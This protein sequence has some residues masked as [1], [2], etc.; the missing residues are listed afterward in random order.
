ME[1]MLP[2]AAVVK[3][4]VVGVARAPVQTAEPEPGR[5]Q[6][7]RPIGRV[8]NPPFVTAVAVALG[9]GPAIAEAVAT[10]V[11]PLAWP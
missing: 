4:V 6:L 10:G 8:T 1:P 5:L 9:V 2:L 7:L 11:V 3:V